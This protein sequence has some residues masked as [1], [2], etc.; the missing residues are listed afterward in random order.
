M[1][2]IAANTL[3]NE[4]SIKAIKETAPGSH[5]PRRLNVHLIPAPA[6]PAPP[7]ANRS[8]AEE[9]GP[10]DSQPALAKGN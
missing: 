3:H 2:H 4:P 10:D 8:L 7:G 6:S 1:V 9:I 5:S